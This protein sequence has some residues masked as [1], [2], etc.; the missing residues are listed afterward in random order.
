[1]K[2]PLIPLNTPENLP[3]T[4]TAHFDIANPLYFQPVLP[5]PPQ[6]TK[7]TFHRRVKREG[8]FLPVCLLSGEKRTG[9]YNI[10]TSMV[11]SKSMMLSDKLQ[12]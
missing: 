11:L 2:A 10:W 8:G 3:Q 9:M 6:K 12:L 4:D 1:M 5:E 7:K